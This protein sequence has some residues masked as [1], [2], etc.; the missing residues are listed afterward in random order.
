MIHLSIHNFALF[1]FVNIFFVVF[2]WFGVLFLWNLVL[3]WW[4]YTKFL[5]TA[6]LENPRDMGRRSWKRRTFLRTNYVFGAESS[7]FCRHEIL[8]ST[9]STC[10]CRIQ[11]T[12][13]A[14]SNFLFQHKMSFLFRTSLRMLCHGDIFLFSHSN[15]NIIT[16]QKINKLSF[17]CNPKSL[18][19]FLCITI[20]LYSIF[21]LDI[22]S[23]LIFFVV[24]LQT[25]KLLIIFYSPV[26][27]I[28]K[29]LLSKSFSR[30]KGFLLSRFNV[31]KASKRSSYISKVTGLS[32][33]NFA[34]INTVTGIF[35]GFY[36][37]FKQF[38]IACSISRRLSNGR[39]RKF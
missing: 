2:R 38:S 5:R 9:T 11:I 28:P 25:K 8:L 30:K 31:C 21:A 15:K 26:W 4:S 33:T 7:C 27:Y 29:Q 16:C 32:I 6:I 12:F 24:V 20:V 22:V 34:K 1:H 13:S 23:M 10:F 18:F 39:C 35:Q 17:L 36:L 37:A 19:C 14:T 3:H